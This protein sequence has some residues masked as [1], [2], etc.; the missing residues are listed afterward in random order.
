M[1]VSFV[2]GHR[3]VFPWT[4]IETPA[5]IHVIQ[6]LSQPRV[7]WRVDTASGKTLK[8]RN[9]CTHAVRHRRSK[10]KIVCTIYGLRS[11]GANQ[12]HFHFSLTPLSDSRT[13]C[14]SFLSK[15]LGILKS[16]ASDI[17]TITFFLSR[18]QRAKGSVNTMAAAAPLAS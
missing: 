12:E 2:R 1:A 7:Q 6:R 15:I 17:F 11:E 16:D 14:Y 10:K 13:N 18:T 5:C 4:P 9:A 8:K 3:S